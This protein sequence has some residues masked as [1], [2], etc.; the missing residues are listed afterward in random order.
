MSTQVRWSRCSSWK[1]CSSGAGRATR[2]SLRYRAPLD[3]VSAAVVSV[4]VNL[5]LFFATHAFAGPS[6][7]D[8]LATVVAMGAAFALCALAFV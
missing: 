3:C 5:A 7:I 6:G 8:V 4:I 2:D 1:A